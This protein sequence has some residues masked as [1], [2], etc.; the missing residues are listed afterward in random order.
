MSNPVGRT[1][2]T[3]L[4]SQE[5]SVSNFDSAEEHAVA[6]QVQTQAP[7]TKVRRE[8]KNAQMAR[9]EKELRRSSF[10]MA[11]QAEY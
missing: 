7:E 5:P 3:P 4:R 9:V 11:R 2:K 10:A 8:S 6:G 1:L